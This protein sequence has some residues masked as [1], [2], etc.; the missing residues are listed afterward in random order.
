[1]TNERGDTVYFLP[2]FLEDP[3]KILEEERKPL[4]VRMGPR[5]LEYSRG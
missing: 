2:S 3:W 5:G 4:K 1:V